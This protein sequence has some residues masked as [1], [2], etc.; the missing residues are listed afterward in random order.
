M[1]IEDRDDAHVITHALAK[2]TLSR[3][4]SNDTDQVAFRNGLVDLGRLC[5][6]EI[7]D[8]MM[9]TEYVSITTPLAETT[10][11]VVKGLENVVI[12]NVLRAAT[13]FVEGLI[14]VFPLARQGVISAGRDEDAGMD[15]AGEFP[16]TVD[17][18][19]IPNITAE[20]TVIVA[21]PMLATGST[22]LAVLDEVL[23][24]GDPERLL[25]LSAVSAPPGLLR[26]AERFPRVDLLTVSID[27]RLD[28]D[29][30]IVPG[31]GDA[32]DRA[33]GT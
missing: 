29:G 13:P 5:G 26:V 2:H 33:F 12:I 4:R 24:V 20:D 25:V 6:Y 7:I 21:D 23:A 14:E 3:L 27:E 9:D 19:K 16:I 30:Y 28:G 10:G 11:E 32:G 15:E 17:Y 18:V 31:V 22:M 1:P 8:G